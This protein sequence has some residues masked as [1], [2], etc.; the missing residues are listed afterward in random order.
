HQATHSAHA[1]AGQLQ[2]AGQ[3]VLRQVDQ[4]G[5]DLRRRAEDAAAEL[6]RQAAA[7]RQQAGQRA[8]DLVKA[9]QDGRD[10]LV[11]FANRLLNTK[12]TAFD[13]TSTGSLTFNFL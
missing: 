6:G 1:A 7:G 3:A 9:A 5:S 12:V 4:A 2:Q 13:F 10:Q 11:A 8:K